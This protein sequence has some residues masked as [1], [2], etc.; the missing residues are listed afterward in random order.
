MS[1]NSVF[2]DPRQTQG[3]TIPGNPVESFA[4]VVTDFGAIGDGVTDDTA[5]FQAA[6]DSIPST[7]F[8]AIIAPPGEYLLNSNVT[9]TNK[10]TLFIFV[11]G[12][13]VT[14]AGILQYDIKEEN[15]INAIYS[16]PT[17]DILFDTEGNSIT[18]L[19]GWD[20]ARLRFGGSMGNNDNEHFS[21]IQARVPTT[22]A[23][24][25]YQKNGLMVTVT[26]EDDST[27]YKLDSVGI[28]GTGIIAA[29]NTNGR[30]FGINAFAEIKTGGD[31]NLVGLEVN[32]KN[33]GTVV[34]TT[35]SGLPKVGQKIVTKSGACT[36]GLVIGAGDGDG[37]IKGIEILTG[38]IYTS[39]SAARAITSEGTFSVYAT[40]LTTVGKATSNNA[41]Q[42][43]ELEPDGDIVQS[44]SGFPVTTFRNITTPAAAQNVGRLLFQG[45]N[46]AGTN[47]NFG[48]ITSVAI[49]VGV[50]T[51][52]GNMAFSTYRAGVA[53]V[54]FD[55]QNGLRVGA[56]TGGYKGFGTLN[57]AT[58]IYEN[59]VRVALQNA[60]AVTGSRGGNAALQSLLTVLASAG[61]ITDNTTA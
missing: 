17:K 52:Y 48:A 38:A 34:P 30:A 31:G 49:N 26:T 19:S 16:E 23:T 4:I 22:G 42:G 21:V 24:S 61:I 57:V 11:P 6:I 60:T 40:G 9:Y 53:Q 3:G 12:A 56:P 43:T 2:N 37:W 5:A 7:E 18:D 46:T 45:P 35:G 13:S 51:E 41:V 36:S 8:R 25:N 59:N 54:E 20:A 33:E 27:G 44:K 28:M 47:F 29:T 55:I 39:D 50:G 58:G 14:G 1:F 15:G 10:N 32:V